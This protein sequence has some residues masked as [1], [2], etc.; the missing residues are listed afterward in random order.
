M[1]PAYI[2]QFKVLL[3]LLMTLKKGK[4]VVKFHSFTSIANFLRDE[5]LTKDEQDNIARKALKRLA[6]SHQEVDL[7]NYYESIFNVYL[8]KEVCL[9]S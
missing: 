6:S 7:I 1:V 2:L 9:N 5:L 4:R 3:M 8:K